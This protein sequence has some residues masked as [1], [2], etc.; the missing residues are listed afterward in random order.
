MTLLDERPKTDWLGSSQPEA[1]DEPP[2]FR[3]EAS[4]YRRHPA[5]AKRIRVRLTVAR[6]L[7]AL[8]ATGLLV[9]AV[10]GIVS[11]T[12]ISSIKSLTAQLAVLETA[13]ADA[14]GLQQ[15]VTEV[16]TDETA[17]LLASTPSEAAQ[18]TRITSESVNS[19]NQQAASA[20]T[21]V[22]PPAVKASL[23]TSRRDSIAF[24]QLATQTLAA[25]LHHTG[26]ATAT[27]SVFLNREARSSNVQNE[28]ANATSQ[29]TAAAQANAKAVQ[30][31]G[32][33]V[34]LIVLLAC[35]IGLIALLG[36]SIVITRA[37]TRPLRRS[38]DALGAVSDGDYTVSI[39]ESGDDEL[40]EL[41][42]A[43]NVAVANVRG[44]FTEIDRSAD[45][46]ASTS[47]EFSAVSAQ[48][49][50]NAEETS[51]Q[52]GTVSSSAVEVDAGAQS[53]ASSA[54]EMTTAI[55][56]I[57]R[58]SSEAARI[59]GD[60]VGIAERTNQT[61]AKLGDS[62]AEIGKVVQMI[63][64]I[65]EQTNLLALNATIEA[66]RAGEAGK[67][68]AVVA[69]EVK[70]LA[71]QTADATNDVIERITAIQEDTEA[72]VTAIGEITSTVES[73][74]DLQNAVA[75][76][77]EEQ[78]ATTSE[79]TRSIT[80]VAA[81]STT[82]SENITS[83]A[84]AA[85]STATGAESIQSAARDLAG[86]AGEMK[87]LVRKSHLLNGKRPHPRRRRQPRCLTHLTRWTTRSSPSFSSR[88]ERTSNS[89]TGI[90]WRSRAHRMTGICLRRSSAR[91][92]RSRAPRPFSALDNS[93]GSPTRGRACWRSC[94]TG[95]CVSTRR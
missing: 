12:N 3:H 48:L 91:C 37:I 16:V 11:Y 33:S 61:V 30:S 5:P 55:G 25:N 73:I 2:T 18:V 74:N 32:G 1:L 35:I 22:L 79:I 89:S 20:G 36:M 14:V 82:I 8:S 75:S 39:A 69:A 94:A 51:A 84:Q 88:A 63:T 7:G 65:A 53:V 45:R 28:L 21:L 34:Q 4:T 71:Q 17:A 29:I 13:R 42:K 44:A 15:A 58:N 90:S 26:G 56:E 19:L 85:G 66:A 81:G 6:K 24:G 43:L 47:E 23:D 83:V 41:A 87:T 78:S 93:S 77:I 72:A 64:S 70:S 57:A 80:E 49:G 50:A 86:V 31:K 62:S 67:G 27:W 54:E 9:A 76:A 95:C 10:L 60:A 38:V 92:T 68:F 46:L 40:T 52:A 59:A